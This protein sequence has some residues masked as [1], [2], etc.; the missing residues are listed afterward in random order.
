M[1]TMTS[2]FSRCLPEGAVVVRTPAEDVLLNGGNPS[3]VW[4]FLN[5]PLPMSY[6]S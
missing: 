3:Q 5:Q 4:A 1:A 2:F 6:R